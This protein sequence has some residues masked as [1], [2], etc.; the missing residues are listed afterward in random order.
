MTLVLIDEDR[1]E[2][3][4]EAYTDLNKIERENGIEPTDCP[5]LYGRWSPPAKPVKEY[6]PLI[7][8]YS[9][10]QVVRVNHTGASASASFLPPEVF[11]TRPI[12]PRFP[13]QPG[14]GAMGAH[15]LSL[16]FGFD[17]IGPG[18]DA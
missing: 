4:R 3:V 9:G 13:D 12:P 8:P 6:R 11:P 15:G 14:S 2:A 1:R 10:Q 18:S 17:Y 16:M 7:H 5:A